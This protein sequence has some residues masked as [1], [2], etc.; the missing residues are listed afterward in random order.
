MP[1]NIFD[2]WDVLADAI[3]KRKCTPVISNQLMG[4]LI[5]GPESR[6]A[7]SWATRENY[8]LAGQRALTRVAQYLSVTRKDA[9][10]A[11]AR[12]LQFLNEQLLDQA[13]RIPSI[14]P[15]LI[16]EVRRERI[17]TFSQIATDRLK[18]PDF[19]AQPDNPLSVL[20]T[21]DIPVYL[22]TSPHRLIEAALLAYGKQPRTEVY[23]WREDLEESLPTELLPDLGYKPD[24]QT[25][26]VF[27]LH[28]IDDDPAS[29]VLTE[30]DYLEFL[31]KITHD[32]PDTTVMPSAVRNA[33]S[34]HW[35]LLIGYRMHAWDLR[36]L[37]Q[38]MIR[39]KSKRPRSFTV[40]LT[41]EATP[42]LGNTARIQDYL[43]NYFD[44]AQ[45]DIY[46]GAADAFA[47]TLWQETEGG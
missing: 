18:I 43:T 16:A 38:G 1:Q 24:V 42:A 5:F 3:R 31:V 7:D 22:T 11:K 27:H 21:L 37:L 39:G 44:S 15:A 26:L 29:L 23:A 4:N 14:A 41:P 6:I 10:R 28:G 17:L 46:W 19:K 32:L 47:Q 2:H 33:V 20:A 40:Q 35:L 12:Y 45:F 8:P 30:D 9:V 34:N 13:S 36:V 25:P